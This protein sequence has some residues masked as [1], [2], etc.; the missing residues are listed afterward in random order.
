MF[1][2]LADFDF[3][4]AGEGERMFC[5]RVCGG[6]GMIFWWGGGRGVCVVV[7]VGWYSFVAC[8]RF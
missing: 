4:T 1:I 7:V 8:L 6:R 5:L 2:L 3:R